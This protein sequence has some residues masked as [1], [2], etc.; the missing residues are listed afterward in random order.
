[1]FLG[2]KRL[3]FNEYLLC[4]RTSLYTCITLTSSSFSFDEYLLCYRTSLYTC[5]TLTS[6]SFSFDEYLLCYRTSFYT[7]FT[8]TSSSFSFIALL[9]VL[10]NSF[11]LYNVATNI[12]IAHNMDVS[13]ITGMYV[14]DIDVMIFRYFVPKNAP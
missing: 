10:S 3:S 6:S 12:F 14:H 5:F 13:S 7:C 11:S 4:Y 2:T 9:L 8:L 1:M